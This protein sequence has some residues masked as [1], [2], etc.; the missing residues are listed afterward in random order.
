MDFRK[1]YDKVDRQKLYHRLAETG[2]SGDDL[3]KLKAV[4]SNATVVINGMRTIL[5]KGLPQGS[6]LSPHLF[7]IFID[8]LVTDLATIDDNFW[9][10]TMMLPSGSYHNETLIT[11]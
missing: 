9:V 1:A 3:F 6:V 8:P 11:K 5:T 2:L 7:N 10:Y 4:H